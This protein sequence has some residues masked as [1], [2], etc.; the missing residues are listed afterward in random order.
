MR[1]E[2][3]LNAQDKKQDKFIYNKEINEQMK[4]ERDGA[5]GMQ[6]RQA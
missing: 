1:V 4:K 2:N 3:F 6:F 5:G